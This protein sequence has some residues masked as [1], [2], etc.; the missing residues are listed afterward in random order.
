MGGDQIGE[1]GV[2][3]V[4]EDSRDYG[5]RGL[6]QQCADQRRAERIFRVRGS[7]H[8]TTL[9][10]RATVVKSLYSTSEKENP[11]G[12]VNNSNHPRSVRFRSTSSSTRTLPVA[13]SR[14]TER[15]AA[16]DRAAEGARALQARGR[17]FEPGTA[18]LR[19]SGSPW[20]EIH[21]PLSAKR[22][23]ASRNR[24]GFGVVFDPHR[25][26]NGITL[27]SHVFALR[28]IASESRRLPTVHG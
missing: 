25:A 19:P 5:V 27:T 15:Q 20:R 21:R 23:G 16:A 18:H 2:M 17:P 11:N 26:R 10:D 14:R 1:A 28:S 13:A 12:L 24:Y 22:G 4:E 9:P 6:T 8:L 7:S 3:E